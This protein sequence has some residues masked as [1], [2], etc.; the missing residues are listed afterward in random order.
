M[1]RSE[2]WPQ[3]RQEAKMA[4]IRVKIVMAEKTGDARYALEK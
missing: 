4:W 3:S 2:V 1:V